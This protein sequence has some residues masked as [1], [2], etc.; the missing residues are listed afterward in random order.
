[1]GKV[2][3]TRVRFSAKGSACILRN[4][5]ARMHVSRRYIEVLRYAISRLRNKKA[6][7]DTFTRRERHAFI[8]AVF[9]F[10][11]ANRQEYSDVMTGRGIK[12]PK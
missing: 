12:C 4:I 3:K 1:M 5:V 10:H 8:K 11:R 7:F 2:L 6:T 9:D